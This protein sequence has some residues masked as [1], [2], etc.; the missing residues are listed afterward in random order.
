MTS[1]VRGSFRYVLSI[2]TVAVVAFAAVVFAWPYLSP[3]AVPS[4]AG[5]PPPSAGVPPANSTPPTTSPGPSGGNEAGPGTNGAVPGN[6]TSENLTLTLVPSALSYPLG[7]PVT[8]TL[9]LTDVGAGNESVM[10]GG[11][12]PWLDVRTAAGAAVFNST[13][14]MCPMIISYIVLAPGQSWIRNMSW[15]QQ[16]SS[17]SAVPAG[18]YRLTEYWAAQADVFLSATATVE[19]SSG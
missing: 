9:T 13:A 2:V 4:G 5:T 3:A 14:G 6:G 16:T 18:T 19:I 10:S 11:C 8:F 12:N 15:P 1:S 17:G 7:D